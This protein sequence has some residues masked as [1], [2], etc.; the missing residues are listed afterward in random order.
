MPR[1]AVSDFTTV[2]YDGIA[3]ATSCYLTDTDENAGWPLLQLI[4]SIGHQFKA[5]EDIVRD[6]DA[7]NPGWSSLLDLDRA[8]SNALGYVGMFVGV[9]PLVGLDDADQ[10]DRIRATSGQRRGTPEAIRSAAVPFLVGTKRV[11]IYEREGGAYRFRVR[12]FV[13]ETPD[14]DAVLAAL[15]SEK[16]GGLVMTYDVVGGM[17]YD[18]LDV[19]YG[20]IADMTASGLTYTELSELVP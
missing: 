6:D 7:G 17:S 18:E 15:L 19:E 3:E 9:R 2:L 16:P 10:R 11:D 4:E 20:T 12:T 1:P 13:S 5:F 8:P 14:P